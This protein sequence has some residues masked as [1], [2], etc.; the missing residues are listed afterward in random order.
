M[1]RQCPVE[2][3]GCAVYAT[4]ELAVMRAIF[5]D[6]LG[7]IAREYVGSPMSSRP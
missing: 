2:S 3:M 4:L 6:D 5:D 7:Q 1:D